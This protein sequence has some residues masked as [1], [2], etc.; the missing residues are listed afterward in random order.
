MSIFPND[1]NFGEPCGILSEMGKLESSCIG[2]SPSFH[3]LPQLIL[4]QIYLSSN[5]DEVPMNYFKETLIYH[6]KKSL[7]NELDEY[8]AMGSDY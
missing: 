3:T 6:M 8:E 7:F 2:E 5:Y 4:K 1:L